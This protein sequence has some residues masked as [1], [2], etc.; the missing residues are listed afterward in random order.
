M[1]HPTIH[2]IEKKNTRF[3]ETARSVLDEPINGPPLQIL[4]AIYD[5]QK[6]EPNVSRERPDLPD[7]CG[8]GTMAPPH[9]LRATTGLRANIAEDAGL[10][11]TRCVEKSCIAVFGYDLG[12][13][14]LLR[15]PKATGS[16]GVLL[17]CVLAGL[18][19]NV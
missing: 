2:S 18:T 1:L 3:N 11:S 4:A 13:P 16:R 17:A 7:A 15:P 19:V 5:S 14:G 6:Q 9:D 12:L 8:H 10:V